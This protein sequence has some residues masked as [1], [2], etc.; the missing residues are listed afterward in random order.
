MLLAGLAIGVGLIQIMIACSAL[1]EGGWRMPLF[2]AMILLPLAPLV[3][4]QEVRPWPKPRPIVPLAA[5][6]VSMAVSGA[7]YRWLYQNLNW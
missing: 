6:I 1:L 4:T 5:A 2:L 3:L 7:F